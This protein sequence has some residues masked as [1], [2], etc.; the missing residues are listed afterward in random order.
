MFSYQLINNDHP[1]HYTLFL[2]VVL[3][4][5]AMM[6]EKEETSRAY[7]HAGNTANEASPVARTGI[8]PLD[9]TQAVDDWLA[10][11]GRDP[12]GGVTVR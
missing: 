2:I 7:A 4:C 10:G 8:G 11:P 12:D 5:Q 1:D 6:K 3:R 9:D